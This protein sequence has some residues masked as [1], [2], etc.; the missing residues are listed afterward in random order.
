M[1]PPKNPVKATQRT[2]KIVDALQESNGGGVTEIAERVGMEKSS[3]H[4]YLTTLQ[5]QGYVVKNGTTYHVGSKFLK[6]GASYRNQMQIFK[7]SRP[8]IDELGADIEERVTLL[9][10]ENGKGV[11]LYV[12]GAANSVPGDLDRI[13]SKVYLH[14]TALGKAILAE[15]PSNW[16][17]DVINQ[18]G[19]PKKTDKTISNRN[20]LEGE[21]EVIRE[22]GYA[23]DDEERA[24]GVRCVGA[25]IV[26]G[27]TILGAL[28]ISVPVHRYPGEDWYSDF[29]QPLLETTRVIQLNIEFS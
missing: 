28:S 1:T 14:S 20:E 26:K 7:P 2:F 15:K 4:N 27:D 22:Q 24:S 17:D 25:P 21:L 18:H 6:M 3:V 16:V 19:L 8:I 23:V 9:V 29:V 11:F 10:E 12:K 13:G 5:E